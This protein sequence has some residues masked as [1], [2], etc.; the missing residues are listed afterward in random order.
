MKNSRQADENDEAKSVDKQGTRRGSA[1]CDIAKVPD[2]WKRSRESTTTVLALCF[3]GAVIRNSNPNE[4]SPLHPI[5]AMKYRK[6]TVRQDKSRLSSNN[7]G[8]VDTRL[9]RRTKNADC[10]EYH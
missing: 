4:R 2:A 5:Q 8:K 9:L 10:D 1:H 3:L 6:I 7:P